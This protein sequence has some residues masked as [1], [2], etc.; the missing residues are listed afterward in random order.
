MK[1]SFF[2]HSLLCLNTFFYLSVFI[3][4]SFHNMEIKANARIKKR[5]LRLKD[6]LSELYITWLGTLRS[7]FCFKNTLLPFYLYLIFIVVRLLHYKWSKDFPLWVS[8]S[9][10]PYSLKVQSFGV[11]FYIRGEKRRIL[12][13]INGLIPHSHWR[14]LKR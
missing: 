14:Y 13:L 6:L 11:I 7:I 9:S 5:T 12:G 1:V 3:I 2:L 4:T 8:H 10:A